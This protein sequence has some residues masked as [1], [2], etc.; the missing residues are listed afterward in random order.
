MNAVHVSD[1]YMICAP[2]HACVTL[3]REMTS[4]YTQAQGGFTTEETVAQAICHS[5]AA[6]AAKERFWAYAVGRHCGWPADTCTTICASKH[7]HVQDSQTV[8]ANWKCVTAFHVYYGRNPT[9]VNGNAITATLGLKTWQDN[10]DQPL[11]GPNFCCCI[12]Y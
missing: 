12:A 11:C 4:L 3:G 10:C 2:V 5:A 6:A 9:A 8:N 7:L 1:P